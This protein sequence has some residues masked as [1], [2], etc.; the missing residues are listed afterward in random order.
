[1]NHPIKIHNLHRSGCSWLIFACVAIFNPCILQGQESGLITAGKQFSVVIQDT[2]DRLLGFGI[3]AKNELG[4]GNTIPAFT[5]VLIDA[6]TT[7][8]QIS[9]G[10]SHVLAIMTDGTLE[11]WGANSSAQLST[12]GVN[13]SADPTILDPAD[14]P[15]QLDANTDWTTVAAGANHS[16][17]IRGGDVYG[18]GSNSSGQVGNNSNDVV[19]QAITEIDGTGGWTDVAAG[20]F[21]S[22]GIQSGK[23]YAWGSNS[24]LQL[25]VDGV[26][27]PLSRVP[28]RVGTD[29]DWMA[30]AAG[31]SHSLALKIGGTLYAWGSNSNGQLGL[32]DSQANFAPQKVDVQDSTG[33]EVFFSTIAAGRN[34]SLA[35]DTTGKLW[36]FGSNLDGQLGNGTRS[37]QT[38]P[39]LV[40]DSTTWQYVAGGFNHTVAMK[41]DG[42]LFVAGKNDEGQIGLGGEARATSLTEV[43]LSVLVDVLPDFQILN[44]AVSATTLRP[45]VDVGVQF[46]LFND[47]DDF[48][49]DEGVPLLVDVV[50]SR[51][52]TFG[53]ADDSFL[54]TVEIS[55]TFILGGESIVRN[56]TIE[57]PSGIEQ[58]TYFFGFKA[59]S[60]NSYAE[61]SE[62][63]NDAF[64][65][66]SFNFRPDFSVDA[67]IVGNTQPRAGDELDLSLTFSNIGNDYPA[68]LPALRFRVRLSTEQ[69][70]AG[71]KVFVAEDTFNEGLLFGLPANVSR[72]YTLPSPIASDLYFV[73][74]EIDPDGDVAEFATGN[75]TAFSSEAFAF[76]EDFTITSLLIPASDFE[77]GSQIP[78]KVTIL[79]QGGNYDGTP[80]NI[81]YFYS[82]D[83][84]IDGGDVEIGDPD[85]PVVFAQ[86]LSSGESATV[87][88]SLTLP[89]I[90]VGTYFIGVKVDS[91]DNIAEADEF[92]N[93][94]FSDSAFSLE[95]DLTVRSVTSPGGPFARRDALNGVTVKVANESFFNYPVGTEISILLN[96]S[97]DE[98]FDNTDDIFLN[99]VT[100][101]DGLAGL[102]T[103]DQEPVGTVI[104]DNTPPGSYFVA[105]KVNFASVVESDFTNNVGFSAD[106]DI[107]VAATSIAEAL[108]DHAPTN[109]IVPVISVAGDS[110]WY[111]QDTTTTSQTGFA[112]QSGA[113]GDNESTSFEFTLTLDNPTTVSFDWSVDSEPGFDTLSFTVNGETVTGTIDAG[114][115]ESI[116][117]ISGS[118][119]FQTV[120]VELVP[121]EH[122]LR[123]EY[124]KDF[125]FK[126]GADAAWV[127]ELTVTP[128]VGPDFIL[129]G[130]TFD[131][132]LFTAGVDSISITA[133]G[134]NIGTPLAGGTVPAGF[135]LE[136]QLSPDGEF[137]TDISDNID[138]GD[139]DQ[140]EDLGADNVF[141]YQR[142]FS[143][144]GS[145]T[146]GAY[147]V[148]LRIINGGTI[149]EIT[150]ANNDIVSETAGVEIQQLPDLKIAGINFDGGLF[151]QSDADEILFSVTVVN[152]GEA[153]IVDIFPTTR[154][155]LTIN[156]TIGDTDDIQ[157]ISFVDPKGLASGSQRTL[158][159]TAGIPAGVALGIPYFVGVALDV[160]DVLLEKDETNNSAASANN[161]IVFSEIDIPTA[162]DVPTATFTFPEGFAPWFGQTSVSFDGVDSVQSSAISDG[163]SAAFETEVTIASPTVISFNWMVSSEENK[164]FLQFF[165][166]DV[167]QDQISGEVGFSLA[168]FP[169]DDG[170]FIL[171][172]VFTKDE[173]GS[174]G[175][176]NAFVDELR[177]E[178]PDFQVVSG[179][180]IVDLPDNNVAYL[181]NEDI[182][183]TFTI[184]NLGNGSAPSGSFTYQIVLSTD[185]VVDAADIFFDPVSVAQA[186]IPF[187]GAA[188]ALDTVVVN[189]APIVPITIGVAE[190]YF[191]IIV[192]DGEG[193]L[194]EANDANN[195]LISDNRNITLQ[196]TIALDLAVDADEI[197]F[198]A[199]G[200]DPGTILVF[201]TGGDGTWFGQEATKNDEEFTAN[202]DAAQSPIL[203]P[204]ESSF[205]ETD[206][207][208]PVKLTFSWLIDSDAGNNFLSVS[209]DDKEK[210]RVSGDLVD[211][212]GVESWETVDVFLPAENNTVRWTYFTNDDAG[213]DAGFVDVLRLSEVTQ[214]DFVVGDVVFEGGDF[215]VEQSILTVIVNGRNQGIAASPLAAGFKVSIYLSANDSFDSALDVFL[216]DL[217]QFQDIDADNR[218]VYLADLPIEEP[219]GTNI[220][221]GSYFLI[222][223]VDSDDVVAE[224]DENNNVFVSDTPSIN[225]VKLSDLV[226]SNLSYTPGKFLIGDVLQ[227][228]FEV[229]NI[230][231][232]G[233]GGSNPFTLRV[234]L[235][236]DREVDNTDDSILVEFDETEGLPRGQIRSYQ[237]NLEIPQGTRIGSFHS[238]AVF[239]DSGELIDES[240]EANNVA[241]AD[242]ED[243]F[244]QQVTIDEAVDQPGLLEF[245]TS[246]SVPWFGQ[247]A[248][249]FD[250]DDAAQSGGV[251]DN[252]ISSFS[253]TINFLSPSVVSFYWKVSS[254]R[255]QTPSGGVKEDFLSFKI[256]GVEQ[257]RISGE[258]DFQLRSFP[259]A[260]GTHVVVWS[261]QK[262]DTN[263]AGDDTAYVDQL[264]YLVPDF[265]IVDFQVF[266]VTDTNITE[267][268]TALESGDTIRYE[269]TI[270]NIGSLPIT[271][272]PPYDLR[273]VISRNQTFGDDD[274]FTLDTLTEVAEITIEDDLATAGI[275][276]NQLFIDRTVQIPNNIDVVASFFIGFKIDSGEAIAESAEDNNLVFSANPFLD[277]SPI[278]TLEEALD[279]DPIPGNNIITGG[280]GTWFG[281]VVEFA[282][283]LT[284]DSTL[285]A[286]ESN[287]DA[288]QASPIEFNQEVFMEREIVGPVNLTFYWK[289]SSLFNFNF[290]RFFLNNAELLRISGDK[291]DWEIQR[292]FIPAGTQKVRWSYSKF[293]SAVVGEDTGWVDNIL[294]EEVLLPDLV[295]SSFVTV[296]GE[297]IL[298]LDK[299]FTETADG[300]KLPIEVVV[301]NQGDDLDD[302]VTFDT[303][304]LEVRFSTDLTWG[305][306][307]DILLGE[308]A[309]VE[310]F[311][312]GFRVI[313]SGPLNLSLEIPANSYHLAVRVDPLEDIA[314]ADED[315]NVVFTD[316]RDITVVRLPDLLVGAFLFDNSK[317]FYPEG[318]IV[319]DY[320]IINRGLGDIEGSQ[321]FTSSITARAITP[322]DL[323]TADG[324]PDEVLANSQEIVVFGNFTH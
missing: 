221:P 297:Y 245:Q 65:P 132:G 146:S 223:L 40:D 148:V 42:S 93:T 273:V 263:D 151:F 107:E 295:V 59:D 17:G 79:N 92:N 53:D 199:A 266:D 319:L 289:V 83:Q 49:A 254:E 57:I 322:D 14:S 133:T 312:S 4:T 191:M 102:A 55:Q 71:T 48:Q 150:E 62:I 18:W 203:N 36:A 243:I 15:V 226:P 112:A 159:A 268:P 28:V 38:V 32:G 20:V 126:A 96:L 250:G 313:F 161:D 37:V 304:D 286:G 178:V 299:Q 311:P 196:P 213:G 278:V 183:T 137:E 194:P 77:P 1:M 258:V 123:W 280:D 186:L 110:S 143:I 209:V 130:L 144:D 307:D 279:I 281:Q 66:D 5:P 228:S 91:D 152:G 238:L 204:G 240:D 74:V 9:A 63:N 188:S 170:V 269:L 136:A 310:T 222:A 195:T 29:V 158:T 8:T 205:F 244:V 73:E 98:E 323:D 309:R 298:D 271:G 264:V 76:F 162:I 95:G 160:D 7:I 22:L 296:P 115:P 114:D 300:D 19:V 218:F 81:R 167:L 308:F 272:T 43:D 157:L 100:F 46:T 197:D 181:P 168:S 251:G 260:A 84:F 324:D 233:V 124:A 276:E 69:S 101:T 60:G 165:L 142:T 212:G 293:S 292:V 259:V 41:T 141:S 33:A 75:N 173:A 248:V 320:D 11:G 241:I 246:P 225:I 210:T 85:I 3:N 56:E 291:K 290:L 284:D 125:I 90:D 166:N 72:T 172:W 156:E 287:D 139:L 274:D 145:F 235:T 303:S 231:L 193:A 44:P 10:E 128:E 105:A 113:I 219:P 270:E 318:R 236:D 164:D 12:R 52:A 118:V 174:A 275:F 316:Q 138:L 51:N 127:D 109:L 242:N 265:D 97:L 88:N 261:Y 67:V 16:V 214:P 282:P 2:D 227:L 285:G 26:S 134:E 121:G 70:A 177:F 220:A 25:G 176:D 61:T 129:T 211:N 180:L 305:N 262:D 200:L 140:F 239:A 257:A 135:K 106:A 163:Q 35:I 314:E 306:S 201:S 224:A 253:T 13:P 94:R 68:G 119:A 23:L 153:D 149:T 47:G 39:Q 82:T 217:E 198:A 179:S 131:E 283:G 111:A 185:T 50:V 192:L 116:L 277:I 31:K 317:I 247:S 64:T 237:V 234:V 120:E 45:G 206:I 255:T 104:P 99:T 24:S 249:T 288:A 202:T 122:S 103:S 207:P 54:A 171:K 108:E 34:H 230:G 21:H 189:A 58:G 30:V 294:L 147:F 208:G 155:V 256:D 232:A 87:N 301:V 86:A 6:A 27:V 315:N 215:V 175:D 154:V 182:A 229:A 169:V 321:S 302:G 78:I 267:V 117:P 190:D 252:S 184:E 80:V 89:A 187:D 216:G